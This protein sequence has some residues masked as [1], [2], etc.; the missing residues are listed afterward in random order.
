MFGLSPA[1][2]GGLAGLVLGVI[3]VVIMMAVASQ[4]ERED[5][6]GEEKVRGANLLRA[7]AW[8]D[9]VLFTVVGYFAG[10]MILG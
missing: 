1:L 4:I 7:I 3:S 9:L 6:G 2:T 5:G 8:F 10:P